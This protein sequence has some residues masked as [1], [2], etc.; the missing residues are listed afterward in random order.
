MSQEQRWHAYEC[1]SA[2]LLARGLLDRGYWTQYHTWLDAPKTCNNG[3]LLLELRHERLHPRVYTRHFTSYQ[4]TA[5]VFL[6][7]CWSQNKS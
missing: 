5:W 3:I 2:L 7:Q 6:D 4:M 1:D